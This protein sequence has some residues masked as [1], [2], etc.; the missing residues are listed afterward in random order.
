MDKL[1][2]L[3][4]SIKEGT[5]PAEIATIL[6]VGYPTLTADCS[7]AGKCLATVYKSVISRGAR[8]YSNSWKKLF[9]NMNAVVN[10]LYTNENTRA[11]YLTPLRAPLKHERFD[12]EVY[13]QSTYLMGMGQA[14]SRA[15]KDEYADEVKERNMKRGELVPIYVSQIYTLIDEL[16]RSNNPYELALAVALA[17]GSRAIE[18]F[19]VSQYSIVDGG[20]QQ[21]RVDGVAKEKGGAEVRTIVRNVVRM[22]GAAVVEA[23]RRIRDAL[24]T[25]RGKSRREIT[26]ITNGKGNKVFRAFVL[27]VFMANAGSR[28]D[29]E[30]VRKQLKS[31]TFHKAR[32]IGGNA[33]YQIYGKPKNVPESTYLQEQYGHQSSDSTQSYL[34]IVVVDD[35]ANFTPVQP[36]AAA[37]VNGG[38]LTFLDPYRNARTR[39]QTEE[40]KIRNVIDAYAL[41]VQH[42]IKPT[43]KLIQKKLG[44]SSIVMSKAYRII[45]SA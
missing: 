11:S 9:I 17:T 25:L 3:L 7:N 27:P 19:D 1:N 31:L 36:E 41:L 6:K 18:I 2:K 12:P 10:M 45:K 33:S 28:V 21:V 4:S 22:T 5:T 8:K 20:P 29:S 34:A 40:D 39:S 38:R 24:P 13:T 23:V 30:P 37:D 44:Y 32:Y 15:K 26:Y 16:S 42:G 14:R 43:Q 35:S